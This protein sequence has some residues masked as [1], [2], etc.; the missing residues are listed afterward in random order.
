MNRNLQKFKSRFKEL[1]SNEKYSSDLSSREIFE[2]EKRIF[3][4]TRLNN[5]VRFID[6][7]SIFT[8]YFDDLRIKSEDE[9]IL[10]DIY[11]LRKSNN[12]YNKRGKWR[13]MMELY[14]NLP[15]ELRIYDVDKNGYIKRIS[16]KY[17][18]DR[19]KYIELSI[20]EDYED[21]YKELN[22]P[23]Y[24]IV[25]K[26]KKFKQNEVEMK[27]YKTNN[28]IE[29]VDSKY[30]GL[31]RYKQKKFIAIRSNEDWE[32]LLKLMG[33]NFENRP[34]I[35]LEILNQE[36][37]LEVRDLIHIVGA[38]G[39]GKSTFKYATTFKEVKENELRFGIIEE[40][41]SNVISTVENL[42]SL[43]IN[44]VPIIGTSNEAKYLRNY[45]RSLKNKEKIEDDYILKYLS[46]NCIVKSLVDDEENIAWNPCRKLKE[47]NM[48]VTCPYWEHCGGMLRQRDLIG[49]EVMV[50]T[51]HSLVKGILPEFIDRYQRS[52]YEL[53]Y[54][55]LDLIIVD[56]AD[57]IQSILDSQL[58]PSSHLNYGSDC[59]LNDL[60]KFSSDIKRSNGGLKSINVYSIVKNT[61]VLEENLVVSERIITK[62]NKLN[63]Y[64]K[65]KIITPIEVM[66]D[67]S[68]LLR[69]A[70]GNEKLIGFLENYVSFTDTYAIKEETIDHELNVLFNKIK[71]IHLIEDGY[72][73]TRIKEAVRDYMKVKGINLPTNKKGRDIDEEL[74]VEKV[75]FLIL[76]VQ[77]DY[78]LKFLSNEYESMKFE[79][80]NDSYRIAGL[81]GLSSRIINLVKEPCLGTIYGYKFTRNN[82]LN[83]DVL[84]YEGVGRSLLEN[85]SGLKKHIGLEGPAVVC[86]SGTSFSPGSAHYNLKRKPDILLKGKKEGNIQMTFLPKIEDDRYIKI[87]G[88][89]MDFKE[90]N[91]K[92]L[93]RN[94]I[95]DIRYQ[96][97]NSKGKVLIVVNSYDDCIT[98][99]ETLNYNKLN[100]KIVG[101]EESEIDNIIT[102]DNLENFQELTKGADICVVPLSIISRGYN[103][104]D[105]NGDSYFGSMFFM[106]RPYMVPGDFNSYVQ[107][108]HYTLN[109][110]IEKISS[111]DVDYGIRL[112]K[113]RKLCYVK[114]K[115]ILEISYWAKLDHSE[116][117]IMSWFMIVPIKQAIGRMQ[118]NGNDCE[119]F[120]CDI[121]FCNALANCQR[122]NK[123]NSVFYSWREVLK[124]YMNDKV[125][126][127]LYGNFYAALDKMIE[128]IE[129]QICIHGYEEGEY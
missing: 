58:M 13:K 75:C 96:L 1:V 102:K 93:A 83:I 32:T 28:I 113:L 3:V 25:Y 50:T 21:K 71:S 122:Q 24:E 73:E 90:S 22:Y 78:T 62:F 84:R 129:K 60:K 127:T 126:N 6:G 112:S 91:L 117:E 68:G 70:N 77:I 82:G 52:I 87:S 101:K 27:T 105:S 99:G 107:I 5:R 11:I 35:E 65:N 29:K 61:L 30:K 49:A 104:L 80:N 81:E 74:F 116:R 72:P 55:I 110:I 36:T 115:K 66:K 2:F 10:S 40:N 108:L 46:G 123:E 39:A 121:S 111:M 114:Y 20:S 17:E 41:V 9:K 124:V 8:K 64:I 95:R 15:M 4:I 33:K 69:K 85:W 98:V 59:I 43:G 51:P 18:N 67:I 54:D 94:I 97:E 48:S 56:E 119:V 19:E 57:G 23:E 76:I 120:F 47:D 44:A 12:K 53:F 103:I 45:Y 31:P 42:S 37:S 38:L 109:D 14:L 34:V 100:C 106:I 16:A 86:L 125:I 89:G 88:S 128:D 92:N 79:V 7:W 26:S 63:N 118:R